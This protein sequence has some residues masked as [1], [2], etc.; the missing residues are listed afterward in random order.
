MFAFIKAMLGVIAFIFFLVILIL[1]LTW[2]YI[3]R[4]FS[5]IR[6][7]TKRESERKGK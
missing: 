5:K 4:T 1:L 6:V 3:Y 7:S 2:G